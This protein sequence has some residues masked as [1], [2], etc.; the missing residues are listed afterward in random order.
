MTV[1]ELRNL[2]GLEVEVDFEHGHISEATL[3]SAVGG[4]TQ[5]VWLEVDGED[6]FVPL[7]SLKSVTAKASTL[8][9]A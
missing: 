7:S 4:R 6:L 2:E 3:I 9:Y 1:A 5:E 8:T